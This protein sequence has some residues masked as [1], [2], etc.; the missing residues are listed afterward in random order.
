MG[1]GRHPGARALPPLP[2]T[3]PLHRPSEGR[4]A[5]PAP[6][7]GHLRAAREVPTQC[8]HSHPTGEEAEASHGSAGQRQ[9]PKALPAGSRHTRCHRPTSGQKGLSRD[10]AAVTLHP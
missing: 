1:T 8:P 5:A 4:L 6:D 3:E 2:V 7:T 9:G 10:L